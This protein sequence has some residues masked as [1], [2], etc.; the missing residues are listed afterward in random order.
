M[1]KS[2]RREFNPGP[3]YICRGSAQR[4]QESLI[5]KLRSCG[6]PRGRNVDSSSRR[7]AVDSTQAS[8][9]KGLPRFRLQRT[10]A[11]SFSVK[12]SFTRLVQ[13]GSLGIGHAESSFGSGSGCDIQ[14]NNDPQRQSSARSTKLA[15]TALR[16]T[17]RATT[18]N[19]RRPGSGNS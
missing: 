7:R 5:G 8:L 17:Y 2:R 10:A 1:W 13:F 11:I 19:D 14:R 18:K 6:R 4:G 3:V 9:P 16:S 15:R 12:G